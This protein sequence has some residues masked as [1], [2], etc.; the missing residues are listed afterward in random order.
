MTAASYLLRHGAIY[1]ND[2]DYGTYME[3]VLEKLNAHRGSWT[4]P[5]AVLNGWSSPIT[6]PDQQLEELTPAG[7]EKAMSVA[8]HLLARYPKLVPTT[9]KVYSD[10][11]P[12]T[13]DTARAFMKAFPQDDI[14]LIQIHREDEEFHSTVPHKACP[15]F[16]KAAGQKEMD[17]FVEQYTTGT[18]ARLKPHTPV[19]LTSKD[20]V[21]LQ[22]WCGY[23]SSITGEESDLCGIFTPTDWMGTTPTTH[24]HCKTYPH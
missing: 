22:Q 24:C 4:G 15:A 7:A 14:E 20:I 1:A 18:L 13:K 6:N 8:R 19:K 16:T 11:K 12:R 23:E 17:R 5:L 3:P 10:K 2:D 21:G 9:K